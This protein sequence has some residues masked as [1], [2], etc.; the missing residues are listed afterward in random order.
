MW[1]KQQTK[2]VPHALRLT[3]APY[4]IGQR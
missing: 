3:E 2:D 4:E 1:Q